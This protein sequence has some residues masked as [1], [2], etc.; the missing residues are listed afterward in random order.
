MSPESQ[1]KDLEV[2]VEVQII[3]LKDV[4]Y[5]KTKTVAS[6]LEYRLENPEVTVV[7]RAS[8]EISNVYVHVQRCARAA[9]RTHDTSGKHCDICIMSTTRVV[10]SVFNIFISHTVNRI[11]PKVTNFRTF[12]LSSL[13]KSIT[14]FEG[15]QLFLLRVSKACTHVLK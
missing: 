1:N 9:L 3:D 6:G 10:L 15:S 14:T 5:K 11:L 8:V 7:V 4:Y 2:N 13:Y 12:G